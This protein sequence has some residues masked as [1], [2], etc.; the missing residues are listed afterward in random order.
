MTNHTTSTEEPFIANREALVKLLA[1]LVADAPTVTLDMTV[2][3]KFGNEEG[4]GECG[5]VCCIA[6]AATQ[7]ADGT[8]GQPLSQKLFT[9]LG[10]EE[11]GHDQ[12]WQGVPDK[13]IDY[14][15]I[16]LDRLD[17]E[18]VR[19]ENCIIDLFSD[20]LAPFCCTPKEAAQALRNFDVHGSAL[21]HTVRK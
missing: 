20:V 7:M 13:A 18:V 3:I 15:G 17:V 6:G 2:G 19:D 14:L 1:W 11:V 10:Y 16:D 5:T 8:F 12:L 9:A 4:V 21:W